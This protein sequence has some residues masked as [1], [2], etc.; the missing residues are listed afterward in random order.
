MQKN[1]GT[2][3]KILRATFGIV[4]L[5]L[6]VLKIFG[7][8]WSII[9]GLLGVEILVVAALGYSPLYGILDTSTRKPKLTVEEEVANWTT[10]VPDSE[11]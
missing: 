4:F 3:D 11:K 7:S 8:F 6:S 9:F 10:G 5:A 1:V 2:A